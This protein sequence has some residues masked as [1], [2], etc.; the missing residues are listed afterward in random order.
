[1]KSILL[2][3]LVLLSRTVAAVEKARFDNY[4]VYCLNVETVEQ[5]KELRKLDGNSDGFEFWK[6]ADVGK[7]ADLMVPPHKLAD[8]G[9]LMESMKISHYLKIRNVQEYDEI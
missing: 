8:F 4:R 2:V 7:E 3:S 9:E 1:M 5:L 6:L